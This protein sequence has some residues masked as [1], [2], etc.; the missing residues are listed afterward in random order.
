MRRPWEKNKP[1]FE[2]DELAERANVVAEQR[3]VL[4]Q[5]MLDRE[6]SKA[7]AAGASASA[8]AKRTKPADDTTT[9]KAFKRNSREGRLQIKVDAEKR[10]KQL[11]NIKFQEWMASR[12]NIPVHEA[13]D[14]LKKIQDD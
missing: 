4:K 1:P 2:V 10:V 13:H 12:R 3:A 11:A 6:R 14:A 5:D 7:A 9:S 8:S